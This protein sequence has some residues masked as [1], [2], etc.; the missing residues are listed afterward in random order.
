MPRPL[1]DKIEIIQPNIAHEINLDDR[2]DVEKDKGERIKDKTA[3][4][5]T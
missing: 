4:T 1:L 2:K 3:K 5:W